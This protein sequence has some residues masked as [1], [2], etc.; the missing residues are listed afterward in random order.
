MATIISA[1]D[2]K[3]GD[4]I[5]L[6]GC[7]IVE[8]VVD[9]FYTPITGHVYLTFAPHVGSLDGDYKLSSTTAVTKH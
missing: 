9:T 4:K 1:R 3:I 6:R 5:T 2:V 7:S 8:T